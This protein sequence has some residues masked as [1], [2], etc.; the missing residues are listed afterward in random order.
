VPIESADAN[1]RLVTPITPNAAPVF[2]HVG[3]ERILVRQNLVAETAGGAAQVNVIV[4]AAA[5]SMFVRLVAHAANES[6][7]TFI[8]QPRQSRRPCLDRLDPRI[9]C[10]FQVAR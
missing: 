6:P 9:V 7:V 4:G 3:F 1:K 8:N 10:K 5:F 2:R